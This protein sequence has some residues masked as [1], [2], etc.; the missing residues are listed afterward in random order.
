MK[1]QSLLISILLVTC[2]SNASKFIRVRD[3]EKKVVPVSENAGVL[4]N[5]LWD[6][7]N[8]GKTQF[9][10]QEVLNIV[11]TVNSGTKS[12]S[13]GWGTGV[14]SLFQIT[15]PLN[16]AGFLILANAA[17]LFNYPLSHD[18][19]EVL[20][21]HK[22]TIK[23]STFVHNASVNTAR[24]NFEKAYSSLLKD[25]GQN[26]KD[27]FG[28]FSKNGRINLKAATNFVKSTA[29]SNLANAS[30][31]FIKGMLKG[32]DSENKNSLTLKQFNGFAL[33]IYLLDTLPV[34]KPA[35]KTN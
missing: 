23:K 4:A 14:L 9:S 29:H 35:P 17:L 24:N 6:E 19:S 20:P 30:G 8:G 28:K 34:K 27:F 31:D 16:K 2:Y 3:V 26:A 33:D 32:W 1:I 18:Y 15:A 13:V 11:N 10:V 25:I 12:M 22:M 5:S 21:S 7:Q